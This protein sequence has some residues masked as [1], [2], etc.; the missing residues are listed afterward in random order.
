MLGVDAKCMADRHFDPFF[1]VN[2]LVYIN[3]VTNVESGSITTGETTHTFQI[4]R[5]EIPEGGTEE[6]RL[7][8][9][10]I[11]DELVEDEVLQALYRSMIELIPSYEI[12]GEVPA[13]D[14]NDKVEISYRFWDGTDLTLTFYR[15]NEFYYVIQM[16]DDVWFACDDERFDRVLEQLT[17]VD[18]VLGAN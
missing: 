12:R 4:K 17:S 15:L 6:D 11:N 1:F 14:P 8:S 16:E 3:S 5:S 2:K 10:R 7:Y 9:Y 13:Y 18:Q